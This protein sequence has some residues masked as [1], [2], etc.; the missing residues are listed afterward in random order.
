MKLPGKLTKVNPDFHDFLQQP[1][2]SWF[3]E[4]PK[5]YSLICERF[6]EKTNL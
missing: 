3:K 2:F 1:H 4:F 5:L 6:K